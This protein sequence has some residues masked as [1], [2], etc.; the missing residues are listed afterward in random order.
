MYQLENNNLTVG[1]LFC[2]AGIGGLGFKLAGFKTIYA[3][4]NNPHAVATYNMN[5]EPVAYIADANLIN[6]NELP[7]TDVITAGFPCKPFSVAG[8]NLGLNDVK[9]GNLG[10]I[11]L[12]IISIK[13]PK[14]FLIE[15]VSGLTNKQ[16]KQTFKEMVEFLQQ[17]YNVTHELIDCGDYGVPQKRI[18]VFII[19]IRKDINKFFAF[20]EK[21][22]TKKTIN[23]AIGDLPKIPDNSIKNHDKDCGIRTDEKPFV[24]QIPVGGNWKSLPIDQ[25]KL[26]MKTHFIVVV[27]KHVSYI[28]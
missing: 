4:D 13:K 11:T 20:P 2:G 22:H 19:G 27:V 7:Y 26:F 5:V 21:Q 8:K 10:L 16:H 15:N 9:H 18:R 28:R 17:D 6:I 23:D 24:N 12:N 1:D 3:F 14:A 25:Q